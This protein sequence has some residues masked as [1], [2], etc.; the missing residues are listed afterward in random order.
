MA[1]TE[2]AG[3]CGLRLDYESVRLVAG[4]P[5][6]GTERLTLLLV[7]RLVGGVGRVGALS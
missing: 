5:T 1:T 7:F 6:A 4:L 3:G 2:H